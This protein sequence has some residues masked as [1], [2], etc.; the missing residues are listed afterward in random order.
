[1]TIIIVKLYYILV[2]II[3]VISLQQE[4]SKMSINNLTIAK[5]PDTKPI[6]KATKI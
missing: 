1:M 3:N 6:I 4:V 2:I 5:T